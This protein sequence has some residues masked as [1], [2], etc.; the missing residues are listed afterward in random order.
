MG[1]HKV[2]MVDLV[3]KV[4]QEGH[5]KLSRAEPKPSD[6]QYRD[7]RIAHV[8]YTICWSGKR[9][10]RSIWSIRSILEK[11]GSY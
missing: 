1:R 3:L 11:N 5:E 8:H 4:E 10:N 9:L 2:P 6:M 7:S